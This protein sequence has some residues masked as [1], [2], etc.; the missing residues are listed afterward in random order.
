MSARGTNNRNLLMI[1]VIGER[2]GGKKTEN[3]SN[4]AENQGETEGQ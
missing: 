1:H 4:T 2:W 3:P